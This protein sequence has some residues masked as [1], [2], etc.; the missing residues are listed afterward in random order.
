V[1]GR[2]ASTCISTR[3]G[4]G[5]RARLQIAWG[6]EVLAMFPPCLLSIIRSDP[7]LRPTMKR[8]ALVI[9][10]TALFALTL[11]GIW[12]F[13]VDGGR[14][15]RE[16]K[17]GDNIESKSPLPGAVP[18]A[19]APAGSTPVPSESWAA[20]I[21]NVYNAPIAF[22]GKVQDQNGMPISGAAVAFGAIDRFW[23]SGSNYQ[24]VSDSQGLF[25][26]SG[27]KGVGLTV[28]VS[29]SGYDGIDGLSY[30]SFGFGMPPDSTRKIAP[31][32]DNPAL[33]VLRRKT[34]PEALFVIRRNFGIPKDGT[35]VDINLM[36]GKTSSRGTGDLTV[37]CW[38]SD[39]NKDAQGRYDWRMRLSVSDGGV[40]IRK[41]PQMDFEAPE[42]G[43]AETLEVRMPRESAQWR[44]DS[45]AEYWIKLRSGVFGRMRLRMTTGGDHFATVAAY[46]NPSGSRN[47]EY[48]E[49]KVINR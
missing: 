42:N 4:G 6:W 21:H 39:V 48:G 11:L 18:I 36:T 44:L 7:E 40:A 41:D 2:P 35:P 17:I 19:D 9:V 28:G 43:Y 14:A 1:L 38:T 8:S 37:E 45:D 16:A 24:A 31:T 30:Q 33:F 15:R 32:K 13:T 12:S 23:E 3:P 49:N 5:R 46:I 34:S 47:L 22:F 26:I 25:S 27:I 10:A 20:I 29:K